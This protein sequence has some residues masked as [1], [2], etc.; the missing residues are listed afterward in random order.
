M[1]RLSLQ[2]F[3][4]LDIALCSVITAAVVA[5]WYAGDFHTLHTGDDIVYSLSSIYRWTVFV[6]DYDHI[7]ALVPFLVSFVKRPYWNLLA[8][9]TL[10]SFMFLSGLALW[11]SLLSARKTTLA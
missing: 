1:K 2:P 9:T 7:G 10:T 8:Q 4:L 3:S 6:W 11:G 5:I